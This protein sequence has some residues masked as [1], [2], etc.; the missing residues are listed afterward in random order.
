M[1]DGKKILIGQLKVIWEDYTSGFLL[2]FKKHYKTLAIHLRKQ[3]ALDADPK[4]TQKIN[5]TGNL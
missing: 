4:V 2:D 5:F 3:Q 1:I